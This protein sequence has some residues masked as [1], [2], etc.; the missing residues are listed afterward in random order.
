MGEGNKWNKVNTDI[1]FNWKLNMDKLQCEVLETKADIITFQEVDTFRATDKLYNLQDRMAALGYEGIHQQKVGGGNG[2]FGYVDGPAIF[3][4]AN[5]FERAGP[6]KIITFDS[7]KGVT[8][9][10]RKDNNPRDRA[11]QIGIMV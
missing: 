3:W 10:D 2:L 6:M 7:K 8:F 1:L 5:K 11:S 4:D 9:A